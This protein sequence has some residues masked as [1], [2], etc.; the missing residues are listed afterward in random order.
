MIVS[1]VPF[2]TPKAAPFEPTLN[3]AEP[4]PPFETVNPF[5]TASE[6][7]PSVLVVAYT[8]RRPPSNWAFVFAPLTEKNCM[9]SAATSALVLPVRLYGVVGPY[10]LGNEVANQLAS[11]VEVGPPLKLLINA[12]PF[13]LCQKPIVAVSPR[14]RAESCSSSPKS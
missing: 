11:D 14:T 12:W 2:G 1:T 7:A 8:A 3:V 5:C 4:V 10:R 9:N 13:L 6:L